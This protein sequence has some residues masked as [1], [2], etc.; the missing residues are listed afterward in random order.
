MFLWRCKSACLYHDDD[1]NVSNLLGLAFTPV[2]VKTMME[3]LNHDDLYHEKLIMIMMITMKMII[4]QISWDWP[5][6]DEISGQKGEDT[7]GTIMQI[8]GNDE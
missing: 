5:P 4:H 8:N 6:S 2:E 3:S 1:D 7:R